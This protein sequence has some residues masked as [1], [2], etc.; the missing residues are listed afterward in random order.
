[1]VS[2][3]PLIVSLANESDRVRW[4]EIRCPKGFVKGEVI[5]T[6]ESNQGY[7]AKGG[8]EGPVNAVMD[9]G[10]YM[11]KG[12][13]NSLLFTRRLAR[14][15]LN[16]EERRHEIDSGDFLK[17]TCQNEVQHTEYPNI[18]I[19]SIE[20]QRGEAQRKGYKAPEAFNLSRV[21]YEGWPDHGIPRGDAGLDE[22]VTLIKTVAKEHEKDPKRPIWVHCV[23]GMG[24]TGTFITA[25]SVWQQAL[26]YKA[27]EGQ[28]PSD[29]TLNQM[30]KTAVL[31]GREQRGEYYV[32]TAEQ[33]CFAA[34]A[35]E[36]LLSETEMEAD[37]SS[38]LV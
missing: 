34:K 35:I 26:Q 2:Y 31:R 6:K 13:G 19:Q 5:T 38:P 3:N 17:L 4:A 24:R 21:A 12:I 18:T 14:P 27:K 10:R 11:P 1:M 22:F 23:A 33:L 20:G 37:G 15:T 16:Q 28:L 8:I 30:I 7:I 25:Y 9:E 32:Q 29:A 36:R